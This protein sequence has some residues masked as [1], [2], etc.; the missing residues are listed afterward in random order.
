MTVRFRLA[1]SAVF[2]AIVAGGCSP[3]R[4]GG[5]RLPPRLVFASTAYDV[6]T[7]RQ[8][9]SV[10]ARFT[11]RNAGNMP[12]LVEPPQAGC[13]CE[14][15]T[16]ATVL[17]PGAEGAIELRCSTLQVAGALSRTV[18]V[19]ANDPGQ[20]AT[21]LTLTADVRPVAIAEPAAVYLGHVQRDQEIDMATRLL[22]PRD[23]RGRFG[24]VEVDSRVV[25]AT[26]APLAPRDMPADM[27][28]TQLRLRIDRAA[29]LGPFATTVRVAT[30]QEAVP[31][32]D[33]KVAGI[34]DGAVAWSPRK[35]DFGR[36]A[37]DAEATRVVEIRSTTNRAVSIT[38]ARMEPAV[39]RVDTETMRP[40]RRYRVTARLEGSA[41][42]PLPPGRFQ[43]SVVIDTDAGDQ[44]RVEVPFTARVVKQ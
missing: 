37:A 23:S 36:V 34:V 5:G 39:G 2:G 11:F 1:L 31:M 33:V 14:A 18:T 35:I 32:L 13:E 15:A 7:V 38:G 17:A 26:L 43:G 21:T 4:D 28:G 12:L 19:Y 10:A 22:A 9:D 3:N 25:S 40:G 16:T 44:A 41:V 6:G 20:P 29:P 8:G 24:P 42:R 30:G 27:R